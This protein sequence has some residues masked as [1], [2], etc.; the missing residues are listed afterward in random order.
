M[1][2]KWILFCGA[3]SPVLTIIEL[4]DVKEL[5]YAVA[6]KHLC[7]CIVVMFPSNSHFHPTLMD[8][9]RRLA[10]GKKHKLQLTAYNFASIFESNLK[11]CYNPLYI[12]MEN[13][14]TRNDLEM[15]TKQK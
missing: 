5:S 11:T 6:D 1:L 9:G 10:H 2:W 8:F 7:Q 15:V 4:S 14:M 3:L 12:V 13:A